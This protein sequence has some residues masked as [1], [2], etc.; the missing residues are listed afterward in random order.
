MNKWMHGTNRDQCKGMLYIKYIDM[1]F[2]R[3]NVPFQS[4][5]LNSSDCSEQLN[6]KCIHLK[7]TPTTN[8]DTEILTTNKKQRSL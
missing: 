5:K 8:L 2:P 6:T 1:G 4:T 7:I 3:T